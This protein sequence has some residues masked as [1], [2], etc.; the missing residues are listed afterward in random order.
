MDK[1]MKITEDVVKNPTTLA[2]LLTAIV[3]AIFKSGGYVWRIREDSV[4]SKNVINVLVRVLLKKRLIKAEELEITEWL[5]LG[6]GLK[7]VRIS[8]K[9]EQT[10]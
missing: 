7:G 5:P 6:E 4:M 9:V 2:E 1:E 10:D 8:P 3:D